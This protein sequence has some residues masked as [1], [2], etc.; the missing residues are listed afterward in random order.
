M[1]NSRKGFT[2]VEVMIVIVIIAIL[3]SSLLLSSHAS[4]AEA[5][6]AVVVSELRTMKAAALALYKDNIDIFETDPSYTINAAMLIP[7]VDN[8]DKFNS[9][10]YL[11]LM[12]CADNRW[13]VGYDLDLG[14]KNFD[15]R[16]KLAGRAGATGLLGD[17]DLNIKYTAAHT[18]VFMM[19][20]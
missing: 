7:Y 15:V 20:R 14:R 1:R 13:W 6:A 19:V 9:G 16:A 2:L 5:E 18:Q 4:T 10:S 12:F 8:P 3:A 17:M 11:L